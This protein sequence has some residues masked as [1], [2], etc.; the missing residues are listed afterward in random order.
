[1]AENITLVVTS[2]SAPNAALRALAEGC[3]GRDNHHFIV[4]GDVPSPADFQLEG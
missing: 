4:I 1:M 3:R 2:I